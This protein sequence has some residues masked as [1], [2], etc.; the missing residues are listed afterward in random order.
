MQQPQNTEQP[1]RL[2]RFLKVAEILPLI[3][4]SRTT[5]WRMVKNNQFPKPVR[6]GPVSTAWRETDY[7]T[8]AENPESWTQE[9]TGE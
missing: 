2:P 8:W 5:L 3:S 9:K 1:Q 4:V 6:I 7:L